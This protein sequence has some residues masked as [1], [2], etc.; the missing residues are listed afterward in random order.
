MLVEKKWHLSR[1]EIIGIRHSK[2][3]TLFKRVKHWLTEDIKLHIW[4]ITH[5]TKLHVHTMY[6]KILGHLTKYLKKV[7]SAELIKGKNR[8]KRKKL[9]N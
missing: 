2:V 8:V 4:L 7:I 5:L 6:I 9:L 3:C 1:K